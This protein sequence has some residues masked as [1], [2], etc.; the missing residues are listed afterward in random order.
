MVDGETVNGATASITTVAGVTYW[1]ISGLHGT[2]GMSMLT[3]V[4]DDLSRLQIATA[5][6][7]NIE[8]TSNNGLEHATDNIV[9]A[10]ASAFD[11]GT[12]TVNDIKLYAN[13]LPLTLA[14]E[15]GAGVWGVTISS[16]LNTISLQAPL[17]GTGYIAADSQIRVLV[18][19]INQIINPQS[20]GT[21]EISIRINDMYGLETGSATVPIISSDLVNV[22]GYVNSYIDFNLTTGTDPDTDCSYNSCLDYSGGTTA[23]NYTVDL[24]ELSASRV[25]KSQLS[26]MHSDGYAGEINSI[27][28]DLSTNATAGAVVIVKSSNAGLLSSGSVLIPALTN[29][30]QN[31]T[32]NSGS[33]GFNLPV[34]PDVITGTINLNPACVS[35]SS[36]CGPGLDAKTVF[37]TNSEPL[38][39]GRVR[40]DI[41][42]A[43]SYIDPPGN[44]ADTLTFIVVPTF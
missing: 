39:S 15:P 25:N 18:G 9:V 35:A 43:P 14:A 23:A 24:G 20:V 7:H 10:F 41:A 6:T 3:S 12:I 31:I 30:G 44:Y 34:A 16:S 37:D 33:Y 26:V 11:L 17:S 40:L 19:D 29:D 5:A 28:L 32:A 42:A 36:Y 21:Y 1:V 22:S 8:F 2:G 4:S 13:A 27:F 38:D